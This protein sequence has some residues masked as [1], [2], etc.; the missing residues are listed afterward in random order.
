MG[1]FDLFG[2]KNSSKSV[3]EQIY[4]ALEKAVKNVFKEKK[5]SVRRFSSYY[6]TFDFRKTE[7]SIN[8]LLC[9]NGVAEIE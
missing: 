6:T 5:S 3:E 2:G 9:F 4:K 1:L 8:L 7:G